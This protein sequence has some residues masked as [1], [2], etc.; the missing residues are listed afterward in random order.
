MSGPRCIDCGVLVPRKPGPGRPRLRCDDHRAQA[1]Y[2]SSHRSGAPQRPCMECGELL[3]QG[4][5][6]HRHPECKRPKPPPRLRTMTCQTCGKVEETNR[7]TKRFCS[8]DCAE[9]NRHVRER[10]DRKRYW[11]R[12]EAFEY[13]GEVNESTG[14]VDP[15]HGPH[16]APRLV[17][18]RLDAALA[19]FSL[20]CYRCHRMCWVID[21]H[22]SWGCDKCIVRYTLAHPTPFAVPHWKRLYLSDEERMGSGAHSRQEGTALAQT[23]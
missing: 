13:P 2:L 22:D 1:L 7:P 12:V 10:D 16:L 9:Q 15:W 18:I 3:R 4:Y 6:G 5:T 11:V 19:E 23:A 21:E 8:W 14:R 17:S 20:R